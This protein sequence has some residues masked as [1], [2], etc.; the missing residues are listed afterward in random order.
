MIYELIAF[1][2]CAFLTWRLT[3]SS[4]NQLAHYL[5][6]GLDN[7][8]ITHESQLERL[9]ASAGRYYDERKWLAAEKAYVKVLKLDHKNTAAYRRLG[10]VYSQLKNYEDAAECFEIAVRARATAADYQNLATVYYHLKRYHEVQTSLQKSIAIE[11]SM[12]RYMAL[13]KVQ[14]ILGN[15]AGRDE[16]LRAAHRLDPNSAAVAQARGKN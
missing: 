10:M 12:S 15:A 11:P 8:A 1:V 13:A 9:L 16:T 5:N 6:A 7:E 2:I 3:R 14:G 4:Y